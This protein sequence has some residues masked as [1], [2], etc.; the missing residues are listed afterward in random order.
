MNY[1]EEH[2]I[3]IGLA[4]RA[5]SGKTSV[6]E[7]II[8]KGSL[9]STKHGIKWDHIFYALP[10]YEMATIR[11]S[12]KGHNQ[13][14]RQLYAIHDV[15]YN[16]YGGSP[17][18]LM[19]E[20][21]D[22]VNRV[23]KIQTLKIEEEGTKPR[24]FLQKAGDICREDFENCFATWGTT[25][26][27]QLYRSYNKSLTEEDQELPFAVIISDVRFQNEAEQIL[28]N[29]N[30]IVICFDASQDTLD[31]RLMKRDGKLMDPEH[32]SHRSEQQIDVIKSMATH[33][34]N[35]DNMNIEQQAAATIAALGIKVVQNA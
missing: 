5:G 12:I 3:I 6:A 30:G 14:S 1:R 34:I 23:Q 31:D 27:Y 22:L 25:K 8:P 28:K 20:Y 7:H 9:E 21:L 26:S 11:H 33:V 29:P 24:S 19:P 10:L 15:L 35:T 2:P 17:I 13:N 16:L 18:G 32:A 4:G